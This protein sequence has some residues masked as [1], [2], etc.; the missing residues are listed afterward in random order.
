MEGGLKSE[1]GLE[2][3]RQEDTP[4]LSFLL[5]T[6]RKLTGEL[7]MFSLKPLDLTGADPGLGGRF[8]PPP[9]K[10][11]RQTEQTRVINF[12]VQS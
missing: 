4:G 11:A 2:E 10:Q 8:D 5:F 9:Q 1:A 12:G 6:Q 7:K 3:R